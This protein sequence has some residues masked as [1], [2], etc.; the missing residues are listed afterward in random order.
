MQSRTNS[1]R[2]CVGKSFA[3][4]NPANAIAITTVQQRRVTVRSFKASAG[5]SNPLKRRDVNGWYL[6]GI[7]H[8]RKPRLEHGREALA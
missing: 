6:L 2:A 8:L 1:T 3:R 7:V 5:G 4:A